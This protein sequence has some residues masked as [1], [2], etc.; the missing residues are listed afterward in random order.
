[1]ERAIAS[2][3]QGDLE[4]AFEFAQ[5][6]L[7]AEPNQIDG[8]RIAA[9]YFASKERFR[10]AAET[11]VTLSTLQVRDPNNELLQAFQWHLRAGDLQ[12]AERDLRLAIE[13]V[14]NDARVHR[15]L[16]QLLDSQGRRYEARSHVLVLA[17]QNVVSPRELL[18]L[19]DLSGPFELVSFAGIAGQS[20]VSLFQLGKARYTYIADGKPDEAL[21]IVNKVAE[22][23]GKTPA[24]EA[25][26]GRLLVES[27]KSESLETWMHELPPGTDQHPEYWL[28]IGLWLARHDRDKEAIH[29]L[30]EALRLDPTDRHA[31]RAMS[32][33]LGRLG[34][35]EKAQRTQATLANLDKIFRIATKAD[36][37]QSTWIAE[38][39]QTLTRPWESVGWYRH[40]FQQ[41]RQLASRAEELNQRAAQIREWEKKADVEQIR[42]V[43]VAKMLGFDTRQ[44]PTPELDSIV[45]PEALVKSGPAQSDLKF[46]DV[47]AKSGIVTSFVSDYPLETVDFYLYQANGGGLAALDYDLDGALRSLRRPIGRRPQPDREF[48]S[49]ST[50]SPTARTDV[51][52]RVRR[53]LDDRSGLRSGCV[54]GDVNQDG[55][56][57]LLVAN[58]GQNIVYIN[59]GDGTFRERSD[60]IIENSDR[61]TSSLAVGDLDGDQLPEI[62]EVN[63]LDDPLIFERKCE[64]EH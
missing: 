33:S 53:I 45:T 37:E 7:L 9:S 30:G 18:S 26:R 59:Q 40:A 35:A 48:R 64:G 55:F 14:P 54:R 50:F 32:A 28:A 43:R 36:A 29:A 47:A 1:M 16:A 5:E 2:Y 58:I 27:A 20:G 31:L 51:C 56:P 63:Y 39:L 12:M 15:T 13:R 62:I 38:Q 57:D 21:E 3:S 52:G 8:L 19:I 41:R 24:V 25:F 44:F 6:A 10:E 60:L 34:E 46:Q 49:Q 17:R 11:A 23:I 4:T 22:G 42:D 61:W